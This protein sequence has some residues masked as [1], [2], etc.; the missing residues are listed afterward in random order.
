MQKI[1]W[2]VGHM[3]KSVSQIKQQI[4][5][6]D[7]V[8]QILDA[9]CI[10]ISS[11][12]ELLTIC[13]N[14]PIINIALKSDLADLK[15]KNNDA[16][17]LD[18][19]KKSFVNIVQKIIEN[20]L[21]SQIAKF[22]A[23]GLVNP[24]F[25]CIVLGLPNVGKSSFINAFAKKNKVIVQNRPGV[26][27]A[28]NL[29]KVNKY[30]SIY[31][32]PGIVIKNITKLTDGYILGLIGSI[33]KKVLPIQD[34]VKFAFDFY[35]KFYFNELKK[36]FGFNSELKYQ[37]FLDHIVNK[38][39]FIGKHN[40]YDYIKAYDFLFNVFVNNKICKVDYEKK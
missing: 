17:Y 40:G 7:L 30:C 34:V 4:D 26:T 18:T 9:R 38:Y 36:Y 20:K 22:K 27:K 1:N 5:K 28:I 15:N 6:V 33:N 31:D 14:K 11:N 24:H 37:E 3:A 21:A 19:N 13:K 39:K 10:N 32:T 23:K 12:Q 16:Y 8:I 35:T 2:Y 29:I 25:Y